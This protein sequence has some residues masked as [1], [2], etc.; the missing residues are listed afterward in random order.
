M[1][2]D[3]VADREGE[4]DL[5]KNDQRL[6]IEDQ[7]SRFKDNAYPKISLGLNVIYN[8]IEASGR[9]TRDRQRHKYCC[10]VFETVMQG[11]VLYHGSPK[12]NNPG[13]NHQDNLLSH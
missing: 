1:A 9:F 12:D 5:E 7:R 8:S 2:P 6:N 3:D 11:L 10:R 13:F 4:H